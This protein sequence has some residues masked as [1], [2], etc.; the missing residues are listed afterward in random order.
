MGSDN[1][2]E[3]EI[4]VKGADRAAAAARTA[5]QPFSDYAAKAQGAFKSLRGEAASALGGVVSDLGRVIT[6]GSSI[7]FAGAVQGVQSLEAATSQLS[8]AMKRDWKG[9]QDEVNKLA[10]DLDTAPS[11][12]PTTS[13]MWAG[14]PTI[15]PT[16]KRASRR[17]QSSRRR[18][19]AN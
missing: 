6:V 2:A 11:R 3:V 5:F 13:T 4:D 17:F 19:A 14:K 9:V 12:S 16:R 18:P 10:K 15:S 8:V 7:S 1:K